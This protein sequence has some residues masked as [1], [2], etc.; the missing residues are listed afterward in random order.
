MKPYFLII[1]F[2]IINTSFGQTTTPYLPEIIQQFP[3]V[4]DFTTTATE[5]EAYFTAQSVLGDLSVIMR[6]HN[7]NGPNPDVQ[8][9]AFSGVHSDLEPFLAPDGLSLYFASNRPSEENDTTKDFDIWKVTRSSITAPWSEPLRLPAPVNTDLNE[10]Y[11][12]VAAN[13][14][15]YYTMLDPAMKSEDDI[16]MCTFDGTNY[17]TPVLLGAGVNTSG[18]EYNA[19]VSP[20]ESFLIFGAFNREGAVGRGDLYISFKDESG[21]WA[22]AI[23]LQTPINSVSTDFCP[24]YNTTTGKLFFTSRRASHF[25][26]MDGIHNVETLLQRLH[27]YENG[28]SR[29]YVI[30]FD[31]ILQQLKK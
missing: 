10:F 9:A 21:I 13:G 8:I 17:S 20:D 12:A 29:L 28:S 2:L 30:D 5:N 25:G 4:R 24:F 1:V 27:Q 31:T 7:A 15:L 14:N 6:I 3:N 22:P 16:A 19:Y 11:P 26:S 23:Q 18:A